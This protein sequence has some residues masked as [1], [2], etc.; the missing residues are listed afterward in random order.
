MNEAPAYQKLGEFI[1]TFQRSEEKISDLINLIL[2]TDDELAHILMNELEFSKRIKTL[3][4]LFSRFVDIKN[5]IDKSE[6]KSFHD[7]VV[8][9]SKLSERRNDLIHSKYTIWRTIEGKHGFIRENSKLKGGKGIREEHKEE[10]LP[11]SLDTDIKAISEEL[12]MLEKYRLQI[13]ACLCNE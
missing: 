9:L 2:D 7:M 1:V 10:L 11:E 12:N 8:R 6:R 3:D 5:G 4:V 13:I